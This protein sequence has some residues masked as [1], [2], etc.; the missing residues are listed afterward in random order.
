M[1]Q[2]MTYDSADPLHAIPRSDQT[3]DPEQDHCTQDRGEQREP[4]TATGGIDKEAKQESTDQ[5][6]D[7]THHD[8]DQDAQLGFHDHAGNPARYRAD[9]DVADPTDARQGCRPSKKF[10]SCHNVH[11]ELLTAAP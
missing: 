1:A 4:P 8:V 11:R 3:Q 10:S 5:G 9:N 2:M 6:A 7:D